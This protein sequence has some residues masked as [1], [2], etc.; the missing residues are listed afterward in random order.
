[1]ELLITKAKEL[2][3]AGARQIDPKRIIVREDLAAL[4]NGSTRCENYGLAMS[5]PP[6][7]EGPEKFR[8]WIKQSDASIVVKINVP[9][10]MMFSGELGSLMTQLHNIVAGVEIHAKSLGY[11]NTRSFAGGSCKK[12]FCSSEKNCQVV[13]GSGPCRFPDMARP[14]M[15]GFGID[16]IQLMHEAGWPVKKA[17]RRDTDQDENSGWIAGLVLVAG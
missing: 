14:S 13:N 17:D 1:M 12:L 15:S 5:C 2:G 9:K 8:S 3:A 16:V 7:V 10:D 6:N 11:K 4:C